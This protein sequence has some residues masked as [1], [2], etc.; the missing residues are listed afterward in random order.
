MNDIATV[1]ISRG[2]VNAINRQVVAE[3][4][5]RFA[6][7]EAD[8][9]VKAIVLTGAGKF[10]SFGFDVPEVVDWPKSEFADFVRDFTRLYAAIFTCAK[11][12]VAAINGHAV[13]G[14]CML[15]IACDR[16]IMTT[17]S[18]RIGL[19]ELGFGS[20]VFAG[21]VEMLRFLTGSHNATE[22]L[23][24]AKLYSAEEARDLGLVE[25]AVSDL[26]GR[27]NAV[28]TELASKSGPA[29]ADM[30]RLLRSEVAATMRRVEP[31]SIARF[32]EIW[33][34]D[35][36]RDHLQKISIR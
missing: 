1:T 35:A 3:L 8:A 33:Y 36:T 16:R 13:A 2:K 31:E 4:S 17:G 15:A 30:K 27:V 5:E 20:S 12:V 26:A 22:I 28:A 32:V 7:L 9:A 19:N 23:T 24:S 21:S 14:G 29:F 10:F 11:P 6:E 18:A 34:S 25:E